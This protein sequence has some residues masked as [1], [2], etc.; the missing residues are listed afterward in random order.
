MCCGDGIHHEPSECEATVPSR[1]LGCLQAAAACAHGGWPSGCV[2]L[3]RIEDADAKW[4][5]YTAARATR[6]GWWCSRCPSSK[7][8][9]KMRR[10][11]SRTSLV[12]GYNSKRG[13][14]MQCLINGD[15][16]TRTRENLK[17]ERD[18]DFYQKCPK[19]RR[20]ARRV[21]G[22]L[23]NSANLAHGPMTNSLPGPRVKVEGRHTALE[24]NRTLES[25]GANNVVTDGLR[26][27]WP[28]KEQRQISKPAVREKCQRGRQTEITFA[29][30][31][32]NVLEALACPGGRLPSGA[33]KK[34]EL[35]ALEPWR[36]RKPSHSG[37][38]D[39]WL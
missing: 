8:E 37:R 16:R 26:T 5:T 20:E 35:T 25:V 3:F 39:R 14:R 15:K 28:S 2:L 21:L 1:C 27:G 33:K 24:N 30:A 6:N 32:H 18:D 34:Q 11:P 13:Q 36:N 7:Q 19:A 17:N 22:I 38:E 29:T 12:A 23:G 9:R 31:A 10:R 4:R